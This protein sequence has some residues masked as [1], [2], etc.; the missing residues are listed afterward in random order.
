MET[1]AW[2]YGHWFLPS[3]KLQD[4]SRKIPHK[5]Q[6]RNFLRFEKNGHAA[7]TQSKL[8]PFFFICP[9]SSWSWTRAYLGDVLV[10]EMPNR[11]DLSSPSTSLPSAPPFGSMIFHDDYMWSPK[12]IAE[13]VGGEVVRWGPPG[14]IS[15]DTRKL[16][17]GQWFF[18]IS[19]ANFDGHDLVDEAL[20]TEKGCVGVIGNSVPKNWRKG[21]IKVVGDSN[22]A[23]VNMA[24]FARNRFPGI[25][26]CLTG[27]VGKTT[28]RTMIAL[29]LGCLGRIYQ[30]H[31]NLNAH[32]G[33]AL[34]LI[35]MPMDAKAAV[36]EVGMS[37]KG[38]ILAR[39]RICC[40]SVRVILNVGHSHLEFLDS[41]VDVA[42]AKG[43]LLA[44]AEPG[45]ICV[46]NADDPLVMSIPVP[47]GARKVLFGRG[48]GCDVRLLLAENVDGGHAVRVILET[49]MPNPVNQFDITG[50]KT[51]E[52]AEFK[53]H[54]PGLHL[55]LNA[56]AAA[57]V[58]VSL[59]LPLPQIAELLS[60]FRPAPMRSQMSVTR[61]DIEIINDA[62]NAN[63]QSMIAAINTLKSLDC[64]GKRVCILGD[65]LE[66]GS[67][68][69]DAH[70][71]V[72]KLCCDASS[73]GLIM[74]AGKR[75]L[76]AANRLRPLKKIDVVCGHD[77]ESLAALVA[78]FL[79]PGDVVLVKGSRK[80]EM[81]K[82][83]HAIH[84]I[85]LYNACNWNGYNRIAV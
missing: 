1:L 28:T 56:C 61:S 64:R 62:Y 8:V 49:N 72:L 11:E 15:I 23:L 5:K 82:V 76:A 53:I 20:A 24:K 31:G 43:E 29:A 21:F 35:G 51:S 59:G 66:M 57:A 40:P 6:C 55:A 67:L 26:V 13:A 37:K 85:G 42:K 46:L 9:Q 39:A 44:D 70:D 79:C 84:A 36:I 16:L 75:F 74:L 54:G 34:T 22:V 69:E 19:G 12:E 17:R 18:A 60:R 27:S 83:V 41:L 30:T 7:R 73:I 68:E 10:S 48:V 80:M 4:C 32:V 65:M 58:A 63:L 71:Q 25:V 38:Q 14:T 33:V 77:T 3:N 50:K 52:I 81:E 2:T 78:D 45:D 47:P